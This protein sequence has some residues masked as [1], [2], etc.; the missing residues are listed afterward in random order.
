MNIYTITHVHTGITWSGTMDD[1]IIKACVIS[2]EKG[3][4]EFK[5]AE[6]SN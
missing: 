1:L 2:I 6:S 5:F 4:P 3:R